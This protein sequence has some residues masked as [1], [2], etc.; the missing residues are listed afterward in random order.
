[1]SE[2]FKGL[3]QQV[4]KSL[5]WTKFHIKLPKAQKAR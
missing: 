4:K 2:L 1:M 5:I 3:V